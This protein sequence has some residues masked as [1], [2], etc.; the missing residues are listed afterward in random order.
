MEEGDEY[1]KERVISNQVGSFT[2][3][4]MTHEI[5]TF[6]AIEDIKPKEKGWQA[7]AGIRRKKCSPM[8]KV[9]KGRPH[10]KAEV[11]VN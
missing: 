4:C 3:S 1:Q 8:E 11:P 6:M 2:A 10:R 5:K 7:A 9:K